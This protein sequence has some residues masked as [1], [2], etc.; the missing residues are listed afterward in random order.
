MRLPSIHAWSCGMPGWPPTK[1]SVTYPA[2]L[3]W[4]SLSWNQTEFPAVP[5][6][7]RALWCTSQ[8][9]ISTAQ[10][11]RGGRA[12]LVAFTSAAEPGY[13][14]ESPLWWTTQSRISPWSLVKVRMP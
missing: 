13:T 8:P 10:R 11:W 12:V 14:P 6:K 2:P 4:T 3:W 1:E 7:P 5:E 9:L